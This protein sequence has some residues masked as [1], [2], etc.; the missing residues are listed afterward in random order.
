[1]TQQTIENILLDLEFMTSA[2]MD[3]KEA[4]FLRRHMERRLKELAQIAKVEATTEIK[5]FINNLEVAK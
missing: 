5:N 3:E 4:K 2:T 1:M